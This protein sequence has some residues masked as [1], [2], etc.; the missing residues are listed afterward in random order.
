[1]QGNPPQT[2]FI[3][4]DSLGLQFFWVKQIPSYLL[5]KGDERRIGEKERGF[6][7]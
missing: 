6:R 7:I 1:L 2:S 5:L 3:S 4:E